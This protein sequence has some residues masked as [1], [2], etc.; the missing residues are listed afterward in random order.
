M[1]PGIGVLE[2]GWGEP[3]PPIA[4]PI[5]ETNRKEQEKKFIRPI[6]DDSYAYSIAAV[7]WCSLCVHCHKW[8]TKPE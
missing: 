3:W 6:Y 5:G 2:G 4:L 7:Q 8:R 1:V